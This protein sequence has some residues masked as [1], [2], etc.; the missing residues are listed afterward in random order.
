MKVSRSRSTARQA[1]GNRRRRPGLR[2]ALAGFVARA[3]LGPSREQEWRDF[4]PR[5]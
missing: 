3:Q 1:P 4:Q 5:H 2:A